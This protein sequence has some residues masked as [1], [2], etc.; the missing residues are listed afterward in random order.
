MNFLA[1]NFCFAR[2]MGTYRGHTKAQRAV[3]KHLAGRVVR[4]L[5][6]VQQHV[7]KDAQT[8]EAFIVFENASSHGISVLQADKLDLRPVAATCDAQR[9]IPPWSLLQTRCFQHGAMAI[10]VSSASPVPETGRNT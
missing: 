2:A 7:E 5:V 10:L 9:H 3:L 8:P 6:E 4:F 1:A